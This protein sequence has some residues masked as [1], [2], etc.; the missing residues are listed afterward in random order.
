MTK[1]SRRQPVNQNG[2]SEIGDIIAA[3]DQECFLE[4]LSNRLNRFVPFDLVFMLAFQPQGRPILVYEDFGAGPPQQAIQSYLEGSYLL[5]PF[6]QAYKKNIPPGVYKMSDLAPDAFFESEYYKNHQAK[7]NPAE[8]TDYPT[9]PWPLEMEEVDLL[10]TVGNQQMIAVSIYRHPES[11]DYTATDIAHLHQIFPVVNAALRHYWTH[12]ATKPGKIKQQ[13]DHRRLQG[14][15]IE[16][17][18]DNFG[19][20]VI[21]A[22]EREILCMILQGHSSESVGLQLDISLTTVKTHRRNAYAKL[23]IS[24]QSELLSLFLND[25][26]QGSDHLVPSRL[27]SPADLC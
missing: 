8:E 5:D 17:A 21:T 19:G 9:D 27:F 2:Y 16:R 10:I 14:D 23:S 22:R 4:T 24:S 3:L 12:A 26:H 15:D 25:L 18:L 20:A 1:I 6:Y 7:G 13:I 11:P